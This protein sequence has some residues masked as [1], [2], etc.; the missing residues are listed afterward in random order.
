MPKTY[1]LIY[2]LDVI[3]QPQ[4]SHLHRFIHPGS[5]NEEGWKSIFCSNLDLSGHYISCLVKDYS[6]GRA[7]NVHI[8]HDLVASILEVASHDKPFGFT[9][10]E[11]DLGV[12]KFVY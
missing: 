10:L 8:R 7:Q 5:R 3:E 1:H 2:L 6:G 9:S 4:W 12:N 11:V